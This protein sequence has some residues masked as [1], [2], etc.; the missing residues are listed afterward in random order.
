MIDDFLSVGCSSKIDGDDKEKKFEVP[1][2]AP[3]EIDVGANRIHFSVE[4]T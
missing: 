3:L 4:S 2:F 1:R